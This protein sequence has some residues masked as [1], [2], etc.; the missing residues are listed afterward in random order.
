[1]LKFIKHHYSVASCLFTM[2]IK[3]QIEWLMTFISFVIT[4]PVKCFTALLLI[5]VLVERF[6]PLY[7]WNF[8][9][10]LFMYGLSYTVEGL[11]VTF[12]NAAFR[13][14]KF[15]IRGDF[16]RALVRP[17]SVLFQIM[18]RFFFVG[19]L[20]E[21]V[22]GL[23]I[24]IYG[25]RV[26]AFAVTFPNITKLIIVIIGATFL[27]MAFLVLIGS[28]SFW[29]KR[30]SALFRMT[31]ELVRTTTHFPLTIYPK[32]LQAVFTFILPFAFITFYPCSDFFGFGGL[33]NL[34]LN[35]AFWTPCVGIFMFI[36]SAKVFNSGLKRYES[37]GA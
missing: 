37:A 14:E 29:T 3:K 1:M 36:V 15:I 33:F 7:G 21:A 19:A 11:S 26:T 22:S 28:V 30:S 17:V 32:I 24:L 13:I 2:S 4:I 31:S 9:H 25:C 18:F 12:A 35:V 10:L 34:P 27:R 6:S 8:N 5:Y 16:D 20:L 23:I